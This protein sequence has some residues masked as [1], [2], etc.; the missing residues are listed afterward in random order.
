VVQTRETGTELPGRKGTNR[1]FEG[2]DTGLGETKVSLVVVETT[3]IGGVVKLGVEKYSKVLGLNHSTT[4]MERGVTRISP[5][6]PRLGG[7]NS[8]GT[9]PKF[10]VRETPVE[11]ITVE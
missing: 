7:E 5:S 8:T 6:N 2:K 1:G 11:G 10:K 4:S 3:V 9:L